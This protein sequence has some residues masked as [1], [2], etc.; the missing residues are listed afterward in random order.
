[1]AIIVDIGSATANSYQ[2]LDDANAYFATRLHTETWDNAISTDREKAL[3]WATILLDTLIEWDGA[4]QSETQALAWP[5]INAV[6]KDGYVVRMSTI[7]VQVKRAQAELAML[8][9]SENRM[10]EIDAKG[11]KELWIDRFTRFVFDKEDVKT[12]IPEY[13]MS[14]ISQFGEYIG[15]DAAG[16]KVAVQLVRG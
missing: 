6:D 2:T 3:L 11:I 16:S 9:I 13:I 14:L 10:A 7:P 4:R 5:R 12:V 8:L 15:N 1:M